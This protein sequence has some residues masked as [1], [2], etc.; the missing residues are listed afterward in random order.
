MIPAAPKVPYMAPEELAAICRQFWPQFWQANLARWLPTTDRSVRRWA[1]GRQNVPRDVA[2]RLRLE[3]E[4]RARQ[5]AVIGAEQIGQLRPAV[6][7]FSRN[8]DAVHAAGN[9][10]SSMGYVVTLE[11]GP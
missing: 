8:A 10:L 11:V 7:L 5:P 9:L 1:S 3:A 4:R 6:T 2:C